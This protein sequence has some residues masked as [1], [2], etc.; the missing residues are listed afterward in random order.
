MRFYGKSRP[1]SCLRVGGASRESRDTGSIGRGGG[2]ERNMLLLRDRG[3]GIRVSEM[4][5]RRRGK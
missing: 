1:R 3:C 4:G 5:R 2:S